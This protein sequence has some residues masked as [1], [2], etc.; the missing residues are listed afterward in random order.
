[1]GMFMN[2]YRNEGVGIYL[3]H[4]TMEDTD[5]IIKW[6]NCDEVRTHFIY[7]ELFT[8]EGHEKWIHSMI[9]TGLAVQMII[10]KIEG[11]IPLGSVYIRDIDHHHRKG[12]YGIFIGE[13]VARGQGI[14]TA[15]AE[16]MIKYA[17]QEL[18][19]H[20]LFLRVHG[21]NIQAIRSYEKAGFIKEA[22]LRDDVY[23][24]GEYKDIVLMAIL[25]E[26]RSKG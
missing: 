24:N 9:E 25:N 5:L 20:R 4:I 8:K 11:D 12:E 23:I 19:L 14:G 10:C 7:Q 1:M 15:A 3:R 22:Y 17:F 6:R 18:S 13:T 16:L 26:K 21:D 2:Q